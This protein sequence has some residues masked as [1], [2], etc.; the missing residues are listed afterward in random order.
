[1]VNNSRISDLIR[2]NSADEI[3]DAIAEGEF[4]EMQTFRQ[5][6]IELVWR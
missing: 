1:M 2:E 3:T 4:F 6:L 5:A